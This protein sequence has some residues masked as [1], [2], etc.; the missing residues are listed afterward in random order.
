M[1]RYPVKDPLPFE[2][3]ADDADEIFDLEEDDDSDDDS[4]IETENGVDIETE[5]EELETSSLI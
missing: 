5:N 2:V 3:S 1:N 4:N